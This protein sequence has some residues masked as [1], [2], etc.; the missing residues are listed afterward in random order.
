MLY[1]AAAVSLC[2]SFQADCMPQE[3][4]AVRQCGRRYY[5][6]YHYC[7]TCR[8][9][10]EVSLVVRETVCK[11][12]CDEDSTATLC[13]AIPTDPILW[14]IRACLRK[15]L[16]FDEISILA[17]GV[18]KNFLCLICMMGYSGEAMTWSCTSGRILHCDMQLP[19]YLQR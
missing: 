4:S 1:A 11:R 6:L 3:S 15:L 12:M 10:C 17:K 13:S 18:A 9:L 5:M 8:D 19:R 7:P 2:T 16:A 14:H